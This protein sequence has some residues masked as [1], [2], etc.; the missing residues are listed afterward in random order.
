MRE[1]DMTAEFECVGAQPLQVMGNVARIHVSSKLAGGA[2]SL[3]EMS[4]TRYDSPLHIH[5]HE[6]ETFYVLDGV[7]RVHIPERSVE[8]HV[9]D[10]FY[11]PLGVEQMY[12]VISD[13][14]RWLVLSA[15]GGFD[16]FLVEQS[17]PTAGDEI[18]PDASGGHHQSSASVLSKKGLEVLGP[19]GTMPG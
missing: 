2:F 15:P 10:A 12:Q 18:V 5:H 3:V 1:H 14:A 4:G 11:T 19:P 9:G 7:L 13:E 17:G 8:L 16:E 6:S